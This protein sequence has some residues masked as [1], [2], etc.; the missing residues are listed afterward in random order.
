MIT[1]V[2]TAKLLSSDNSDKMGAT[3][4]TNAIVTMQN[5]VIRGETQELP[6]LAL[7]SD[8]QRKVTMEDLIDGGFTDELRLQ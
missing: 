1:D 7:N 4:N 8:P 3:G 6:E 2:V 5:S